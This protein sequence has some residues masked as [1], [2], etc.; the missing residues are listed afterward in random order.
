MFTQVV[1]TTFT[2][3]K[4]ALL[5][6]FFNAIDAAAFETIEAVFRAEKVANVSVFIARVS[7]HRQPP[8]G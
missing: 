6:I 5:I 7:E 3:K 1:S 4:Q 2:L 8:K